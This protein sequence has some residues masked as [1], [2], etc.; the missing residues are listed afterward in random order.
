MIAIAE[1]D[2]VAVAR[3]VQTALR[4]GAGVDTII[5]RIVRA[6]QGL[7]SPQKYSV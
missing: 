6:Q 1:S 5:N 3:I 4:S 2:E 7:Y